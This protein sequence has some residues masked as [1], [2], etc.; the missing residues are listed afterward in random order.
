MVGEMEFFIRALHEFS[1]TLFSEL[2]MK[3]KI[4]S[5]KVIYL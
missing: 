4:T 2:L 5:K 1:E 3:K